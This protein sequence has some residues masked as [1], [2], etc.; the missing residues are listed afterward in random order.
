MFYVECEKTAEEEK[1]C[2]YCGKSF[3]SAYLGIHIKKIHEGVRCEFC[4][5]M[6]EGP[7]QLTA[8]V[9]VVHEGIKDFTCHLC[10]K[11]FSTKGIMQT[12]MKVTHEGTYI[13]LNF[14]I[15][16]H[17]SFTHRITL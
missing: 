17:N 7:K 12:H 16:E 10:G 2:H 5:K 3:K 15:L 11:T 8:H 1:S 6:F 13:S 14:S 4:D 9:R